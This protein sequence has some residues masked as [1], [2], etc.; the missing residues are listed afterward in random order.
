M[1]KIFFSVNHSGCAWW[2]ARQPAAMIKKL[3]LAEVEIFSQYDTARDDIKR[4]LEWCDMV[5]A[6]S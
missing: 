6:Q 3:G 1:L 4:I 5:V 2:R